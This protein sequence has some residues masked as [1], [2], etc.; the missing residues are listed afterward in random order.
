MWSK[1]STN[2]V[3]VLLLNFVNQPRIFS[4]QE[5]KPVCVWTA[6][7][8]ARFTPGVLLNTARDP[9]KSQSSPAEPLEICHVVLPF[10]HLL[11]VLT[12]TEIFHGFYLLLMKGLRG[13]TCF[14]FHTAVDL[15]HLQRTLTECGWKLHNLH[16]EFHQV[17]KVWILQVSGTVCCSAYGFK[18]P[19]HR[20]SLGTYVFQ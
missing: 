9:C 1:I 12:V 13:S 11:W 4:N 8:L 5:S 19:C 10:Q 20:E 3:F 6:L 14:V 2:T 16:Q 7:E 18:A 15:F 17:S